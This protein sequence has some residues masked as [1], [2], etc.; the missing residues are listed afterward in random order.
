[1]KFGMPFAHTAA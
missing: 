1:V